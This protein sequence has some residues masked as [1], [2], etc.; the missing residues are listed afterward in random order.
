MVSRLHRHTSPRSTPPA[1]LA[2]PLPQLPSLPRPLTLFPLTAHL[3]PQ[4]K[5][6][7]SLQEARK[8]GRPFPFGK[9]GNEDV[10]S[11]SEARSLPTPRWG[12]LALSG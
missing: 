4:L 9:Q 11:S 6:A 1:I 5:A 12:I 8:Q 7:L 10:L 3:Y 2:L